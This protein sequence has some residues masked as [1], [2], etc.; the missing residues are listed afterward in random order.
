MHKH[1][2]TNTH[3]CTSIHIHAPHHPNTHART[4]PP[5]HRHMPP[6]VPALTHTHAHTHTHMLAHMRAGALQGAHSRSIDNLTLLRT[7]ASKS[8]TLSPRTPTR[9]GG[10]TSPRVGMVVPTTTAGSPERAPRV[11]AWAYACVCLYAPVCAC[12]SMCVCARVCARPCACVC[13]AHARMRALRG[14]GCVN[15]WVAC[16]ASCPWGCDTRQSWR[17][18]A[19]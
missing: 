1:T 19:H 4:L 10:S 5:Q 7:S 9:W 6:C 13:D 14:V 12:V 8:V 17:W 2:Y 15:A 3:T 18:C 11:C 16:G